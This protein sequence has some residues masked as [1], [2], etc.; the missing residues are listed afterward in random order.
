[1][2]ITFAG[3]AREVTGSCHILNVGGRTVLL[4]CG[5]FQ[6]ARQESAEKNRAL[7]VPIAE[8]DAVVLSHAHIDHA[9]RLPLLVREGYSKQIFATPATRDLCAVMLADSAHIQEKDA[10]FLAKRRKE[11]VEP[12]YGTRHAVRTIELMIGQP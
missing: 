8:I 12:L 3:A 5:M 9:G 4:D 1:M 2:Q 7:P 6:G 11:F 10:E